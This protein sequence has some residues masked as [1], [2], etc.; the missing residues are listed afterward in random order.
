MKRVLV[1][2]DEPAIL[3]GLSEALA[4][5]RRGIAVV[6]AAGGHEALQILESQKID[7]VLTDLRMPEVDG[8]ELL[9]YLRR[10]LPHVPVI[11]MTAHGADELARVG[12]VADEFECFSKPIDLSALRQHIQDRIAQRVRG[13]VENISLASFLQ[14][15]EM[16]RKT[17]TLSVVAG[18]HHGKL[19]FRGGRLIGAEADGQTGQQAALEIVTWDQADVEIS[20][21]AP[22]VEPT[23]DGGLQFFLMEGMRLKDERE[24]G[25][26]PAAP[27]EARDED[28]ALAGLVHGS[29]FEGLEALGSPEEVAGRIR[30]SLERA[31]EIAGGLGTL[32]VEIGRGAVIGAAGVTEDLDLEGIAD[33]FAQLLRARQLLAQKTAKGDR[34]GFEEAVVTS[35]DRQYLARVLPSGTC[36]LLVAL[37]RAA[38]NLGMARLQLTGLERSLTEKLPALTGAG[39]GASSSGSGRGGGGRKPGR[40]S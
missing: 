13:K 38:A 35:A 25:L 7:L 16:E 26:Q 22:G 12:G 36:F 10:D 40:R 6:T 34:D 4:D 24:R 9:A 18:A 23:L 37:D 28:S 17:C 8:F 1:V 5:A 19:Y 29:A 21:L 39:S 32:L 27:G 31:R 3:F 2:D 14:L 11:L 33:A 15:L 20:D 30:E